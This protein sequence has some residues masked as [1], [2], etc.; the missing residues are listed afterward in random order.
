MCYSDPSSSGYPGRTRVWETRA[1]AKA[2]YPCCILVRFLL[3][4]VAAV[5]LAMY[6]LRL[7]VA[8]TAAFFLVWVAYNQRTGKPRVWWSRT[9][10]IVFLILV[11]GAQILE[12]D[13][14][15][16]LITVVLLALHLVFSSR[17]CYMWYY[18]D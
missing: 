7:P 18:G 4:V 3:Y 2:W 16:W 8:I 15:R 1:R 10:L 13:D 14:V 9:Q 12:N 5:L 6:E 17:V 11:G